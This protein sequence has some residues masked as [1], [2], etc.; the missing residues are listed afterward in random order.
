MGTK[1]FGLGVERGWWNR[2][3]EDIEGSS[4]IKRTVMQRM[5][6]VNKKYK[7][8]ANKFQFSVQNAQLTYII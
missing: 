5:P 8:L 2:G 3:V 4:K 1:G 6:N 7:R